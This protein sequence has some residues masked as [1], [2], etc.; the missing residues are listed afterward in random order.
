MLT[1]HPLKVSEL[2][3]EASDALAIAFEVPESLREAYRFSPGQHLGLRAN[4]EG[5]E[6]RRTY[7][8]CSAADDR[9]LRIGVR[10]HDQGS[11]SQYLASRVRVGDTVEVLTP[12]GG[13][14]A[15]PDPTAAR[16]YCAFV[17]GSGITPILGILSNVLVQ[18]PNSRFLVFYGNRATTTIMFAEELLALKDRYPGR[19]SLYFILSREP[20]DIDLFNGRLD[21]EKVSQ[22]GREVFNP[23]EMDAFFLCGPGM[24]IESVR[25][26]LLKLGADPARIHAERFANDASPATRPVV[27]T[28]DTAIAP[29]KGLTHVTVVMDGRRRS[30]S[31][32]NDATTVLEAAEQ[33]GLELPYSCRAGVCS[34]C[35]TRVTRGAVTMTTNY[36]LESWELDAGY[37]L[38]CQSLPAS[39]ELELNYDER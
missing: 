9:C 19:L 22:L 36:A 18:E 34:T 27:V 6:V 12:T 32:A 24:M 23:K 25:H 2:R 26:A 33:A 17:G 5:Q 16:T 13:F 37:V 38:C 31:M 15:R 14:F 1:F 8:I 10:L 21:Q 28:P 29:A 7:S 20:Q 30:F 3:P 39:A 35:R 11:M 4:I